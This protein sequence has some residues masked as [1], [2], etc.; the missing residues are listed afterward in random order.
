MNITDVGHL[1]GDGDQG[2]DKMEKGAQKEGITARDIAKKYENNFRTYL[3]AL[4]LHFDEHPRATD[5]IQ[6]QIDIVQELENK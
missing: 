1:V 2:Q 6:E 5:Y 4:N 3:A